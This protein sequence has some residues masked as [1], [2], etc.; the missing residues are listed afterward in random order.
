MRTLGKRLA[1]AAVIAA[2]LCGGVMG[3][4]EAEEDGPERLSCNTFNARA[5]LAERRDGVDYEVEA[6]CVLLTPSLT[7]EPG[8]TIAFGAR[9]GLSVGGIQ[10]AGTA[11]APIVLQGVEARAGSWRGLFIE[12]D[13]AGNV[14]EHVQIAHAGGDAFN[15]NGHLGSIILYSGRLNLNTVRLTQGAATGLNAL[16]QAAPAVENLTVTTHQ[17]P[18][19]LSVVHLGVLDATSTLTGNTDDHAVMLTGADIIGEVVVKPTTVPYRVEVSGG[20]E[21]WGVRERG[22]L[23]FN[24]GVTLKMGPKTGLAVS[25]QGTL[26]I[27]GTAEAPVVFEGVTAGPGTWRG[28]ALNSLSESFV[29][30]HLTI[31]GAGG[32]AFDSNGDRASILLGFESTLTLNDAT[33]R[34]SGAECGVKITSMGMLTE[35]GNTYDGVTTPVCY[36]PE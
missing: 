33:I 29:I 24:P 12:S 23:T 20:F 4:G 10:A 31:S 18:A 36:P 3:C 14:L 6:D 27:A 2:G 32:D 22:S 1:L 5:L 34:D 19:T 11:E 28:V 25:D 16:A 17:T 35:T 8:V 15:S 21:V 30:D 13:K 9:S 26:T 7:I